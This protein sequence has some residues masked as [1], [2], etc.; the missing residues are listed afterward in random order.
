VHAFPHPP[1]CRCLTPPG[2]GAGVLV[3][4][5]V[6]RLRSLAA[7]LWT[8]FPP[9]LSSIGPPSIESEGGAVLTVVGANF[10]PSSGAG[11]VLVGAHPCAPLVGVWNHTFIQCVAPP[12]VGSATAVRV[13]VAGQTQAAQWHLD[14]FPP[15]LESVA[16]NVLNTTGGISLTLSGRR[17][18]VDDDL[19]ARALALKGWCAPLLLLAAAAAADRPSCPVCWQVCY[20]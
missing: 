1:T 10:G 11:V 20:C 8:Y 2:V 13:V 12:G 15:V 3:R 16:P 17:F 9:T 18:S 6:S 4:V 7:P 5:V 19:Y 14:Y